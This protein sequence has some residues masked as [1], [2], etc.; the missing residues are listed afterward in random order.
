[1]R[2]SDSDDHN[3]QLK[4]LSE[5][6]LIEE[7]GYSRLVKRSIIF[8]SVM[9]L[10]FILWAIF[11]SVDEVA[12]TFGDV[13]P[14]QDV[15]VIQHLEGGIISQALVKNG[16]EVKAGQIL[17][18]LDTKAVKSELQK[19]L[20]KELSL[21]L[22]S[23]RLNAFVNRV[24]AGKV[25][26]YRKITKSSYDTAENRSQILELVL[27]D[28]ALLN[29]QSQERENQRILAKEKVEQKESQLTQ[30][31]MAK[32]GSEK[33]LELYI[34]EE[35]MLGSLV[36][37]GHVSQ[38]EYIIA[39]RKVVEAR[40]QVDRLTNQIV[41]AKSALKEAKDRLNQ[42]DNTLSEAALKELNLI[43]QQLLETRHNI[44]RLED[45]YKRSTVIAPIMGIVKGLTALPGTVI[46]AGEKL[47]EIIPTEGE[48]LVQTKLNTRDVGYVRVGDPAEVKIT[49]FD[50]ARYGSVKGRVIEISASTFT[51]KEGL[52]YYQTK[53]ALE[54]NYVGNDPK[55]NLLKPGMTV[56]A[57]IITNKKSIM[58]YILKPI[59]RAFDSSFRER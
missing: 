24:P 39:Q 49:A 17:M 22:D 43:D 23:E 26:W 4:Y 56:Q 50:F 20:G 33:Q 8:I 36:D 27:A 14:V 3:T 57:D 54:K 37:Q 52:P 53:V 19:S 42:L 1:M 31:E 59:T 46:P 11:T 51:S 18:Q 40:D 48:M 34:K 9:L 10:C 13:Q 25:D 41:E 35:K 21:I 6:K 45:I 32:N 47:M 30:L 15:Q 12:V 2:P 58:S 29:Q 55:K 16:D 28:I 44:Q 7:G 5:V 38:R